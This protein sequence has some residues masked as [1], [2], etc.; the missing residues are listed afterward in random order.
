MLRRRMVRP[1]R[2][3]E[4]CSQFRPRQRRGPGRAPVP[5]GPPS[6]VTMFIAVPG[7]EAVAVRAAVGDAGEANARRGQSSSGGVTQEDSISQTPSDWTKQ[8]HGSASPA[9]EH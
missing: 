9:I 8:L 6:R 5:E 4:C 3:I 1:C 7:E 2:M